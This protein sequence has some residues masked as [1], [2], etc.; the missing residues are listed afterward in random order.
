VVVAAVTTRSWVWWGIVAAAA[1]IIA[2]PGILRWTADRLEAIKRAGDGPPPPACLVVPGRSMGNTKIGASFRAYVAGGP[3]T[4]QDGAN[5]LAILPDGMQMAMTD[6][7]TETQIVVAHGDE[8]VSISTYLSD[9][10]T[11]DGIKF[12]SS[13]EDVLRIAGHPRRIVPVAANT[14]LD[15]SDRREVLEYPGIR[16]FVTEHPK[17][18]TGKTLVDGIEVFKEP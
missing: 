17:A 3:K 9:C 10:H 6:L 16:F 4:D 15:A 8:I 2:W 18:T 11:Q 12:L 7:E 5:V 14:I 1:A 13:R